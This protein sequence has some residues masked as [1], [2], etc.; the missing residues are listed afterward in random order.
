[1]N[2]KEKSECIIRVEENGIQD[3]ARFIYWKL[4]LVRFHRLEFQ[5]ADQWKR[6]SRVRHVIG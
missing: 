6:L 3:K 2:T 4:T 5:I 1:M